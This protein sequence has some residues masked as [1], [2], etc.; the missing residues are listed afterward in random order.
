MQTFSRSHCVFHR[1]WKATFWFHLSRAAF[2]SSKHLSQI[3]TEHK[4]T[5]FLSFN[6]DFSLADWFG[7]GFWRKYK[8]PSTARLNYIIFRW[9]IKK[10]PNKIHSSLWLQCKKWKRVQGCV[11]TFA[12]YSNNSEKVF[13]FYVNLTAVE[14]FLDRKTLNFWQNSF[15]HCTNKQ[16]HPKEERVGLLCC[17]LPP[18]GPWGVI[19]V[20]IC[21][22][23]RQDGVRKEVEDEGC[24]L[25]WFH[26]TQLL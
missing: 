23:N 25:K 21:N 3:E 6:N 16:T 12:K 15:H 26:W 13:F 7:R 22:I 20:F 4:I 18:W 24:L 5:F 11:N 17:Q 10:N 2:V 8:F 19:N 9:F 1:D 14:K